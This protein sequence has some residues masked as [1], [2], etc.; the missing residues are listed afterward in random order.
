LYNPATGRFNAT[1]SMNGPRGPN[2]GTLLP[3]GDVLVTGKATLFAE[4]YNPATGQWSNA[5]AGLPVCLS[6]QE[7]RIFSTATLLGTGNVLVAGGLVGLIQGSHPDLAPQVQA[8][9]LARLLTERI[10]FGELTRFDTE[11]ADAWRLAADV[12]HS[13][14]LRI[15]LRLVQACRYFVA[16]D[17]AR[18]AD[19]TESCYRAQLNLITDDREPGR[20]LLDSC[21]MLLTGTLADHAEQMTAR[22]G[23]ARPCVH[24]AP[25]RPGRGAGLR[26]ARRTRAG[27]P[28]RIPLVRAAAAV[29]YLDAGDLLLG[30]G[31]GHTGGPGPGLAV[32]SARAARRRTGHRRHGHRRRRSR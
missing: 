7:C 1:G 29:V 21:R 9:L 17:V 26:P 2:V 13:P 5:S 6:N 31:R 14:E 25:G 24:P 32:R 19:L 28:D 10:R 3:D 18:G 22:L 8:I 12:L 4:L 23:P 16:G 15:A 27:T 20:F 11:F 30:P